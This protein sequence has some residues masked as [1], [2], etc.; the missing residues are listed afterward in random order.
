MISSYSYPLSPTGRRNAVVEDTGR[1]VDYSFDAL[2]RLTREKIIDAVFG[3]RTIDYTYDAV[4]N[5]LTRADSVEG[6][7]SYIYDAMDRLDTETLAG[8]VA[9]YTYDK[10][11]NTLSRV[12]SATDQV[13]YTWDFAN[14]LIAADTNG[15]GVIDARNVYDADGNRVSQTVSGQETRLLIDTVQR[16]AQVLLEYRPSGLITA[17][18]VFGNSLISQNRGVDKSFYQVDG[19]GS[20]RALTNVSGLVT[21]RYLYDAFGRMIARSGKTVN[22]YLFAGQQRDSALGLDYLRARFLNS[23]TGRFASSDS[24]S[25]VIRNPLSLHKYLY[26]A[27][28]PVNL[29]DP[30]GHFFEFIGG[31]ISALSDVLNR[32]GSIVQAKS[33]IS[34]ARGVEDFLLITA[35]G[36]EVATVALVSGFETSFT[37]GQHDGREGARIKSIE[38]K[39]AVQAGKDSILALE[40][41]TKESPKFN[42]KLNLTDPSESQIELGQELHL[43]IASI[44]AAGFI[45]VLQLDLVFESQVIPSFSAKLGFEGKFGPGG[46]LKGKIP[47]LEFNS[48]GAQFL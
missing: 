32:V 14:R 31:A 25:G 29:I 20:T 13:F 28:N 22:A 10:N 44:M 6:V 18:Y 12:A 5:R 15:D 26:T 19:L 37:I 4:G 8:D 24:F 38:L 46:L 43:E 34:I 11:G 33:F 2:D 39:L 36:L 30:S 21:D 16:Y 9:Q 40:L 42:F 47:L 23:G 45:T 1:R 41:E 3:D 35:F 17:S 48:S 27:Q 7:T